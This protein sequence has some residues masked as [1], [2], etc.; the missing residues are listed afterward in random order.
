M[1][2]P[3]ISVAQMREW[4]Q[5]TW[6]AGQKESVVIQNVGK[7]LAHAALKLTR[8]GDRILVLAGKGHNGE[9]ARQAVLHLLKRETVLLDVSDP[10]AALGEISRELDRKPALVIDGLFG[11]GLNRPLDEGWCKLIEKINQS[12]ALVLSVDVPSGLDAD[13]GMPRGAAIQAAVTL[14]VGAPK[15]G[16]I[17]TKAY[18]YVGRLEVA[19]QV[20]LLP[21]PFSGDLWWTMPGDFDGFL[22]RRK[23]DGHKGAYGHLHI[24]AGSL[25]YHGA[26]VLSARGA[27]RARPGLVTLMT[28]PSVH[29][30]VASQLAAAM[31]RVFAKEV[32]LADLGTALVYGPGLAGEDVSN[33]LR[34]ETTRLWQHS[35][36]PVIADATG[37]DWTPPG[38]FTSK[39]QRVITPHPGEA[40]RML[41]T[42]VA[43]VQADRLGTA[44][45][46]SRRWGECFVVLKGHQTVIARNSGPIYINSSGNPGLA[47][48]GSGDVLAGYLGGLLAQ[49]ELQKSIHQTIRYGV[50]Q[51][52]MAADECER[53]AENWGVDE[54]LQSLGRSKLEVP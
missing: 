40:A 45:E 48:G 15:R 35:H 32:R 23:V 46:I 18:P 2:L 11:L 9:D 52:G 24:I 8:Q 31:V 26:A 22:P 17:E 43:S 6:A 33:E 54:L 12:R 16:L 44:R 36:L 50:W 38:Q 34:F 13:T 5:A 3:L 51:H 1:S 37:L 10:T 27:L 14:T 25:G 21:C 39:P 47:Q 4:E 20:G 29:T 42:S 41:K 49:P 7:E 19:A 53:T 30:P 28:L